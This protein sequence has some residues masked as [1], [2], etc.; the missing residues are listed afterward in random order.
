MQLAPIFINFFTLKAKAMVNQLNRLF[1]N[2]QNIY[3][4]LHELIVNKLQSELDSQ[5]TELLYWNDVQNL[6]KLGKVNRNTREQKKAEIKHMNPSQIEFIERIGYIPIKDS[7]AFAHFLTCLPL[8]SEQVMGYNEKKKTDCNPEKLHLLILYN[9]R[10]RLIELNDIDAKE[11][12]SIKEKDGQ[13]VYKVNL[14]KLFQMSRKYD[15]EAPNTRPM[16]NIQKEAQPVRTTS[17]STSTHD[18][19]IA[20]EPLISK[21]I[22]KG[23]SQTKKTSYQTLKDQNRKSTQELNVLKKTKNNSELQL[24]ILKNENLQLKKEKENQ[25]NTNCIN[26]LDELSSSEIPFPKPVP[27]NE[28]LLRIDMGSMDSP[29]RPQEMYSISDRHEESH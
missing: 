15:R 7:Y 3:L 1:N 17:I 2:N 28:P 8:T 29:T 27:N 13:K 11:L 26:I 18:R 23:Q 14:A 12:Y 4:S 9:G 20:E 10:F 22:K 24:L 16:E 25:Q 5:P 19:Q 21:K 6:F